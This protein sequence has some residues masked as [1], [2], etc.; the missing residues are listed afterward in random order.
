[1]V[2]GSETI[3][4]LLAGGYEV[5]ITISGQITRANIKW[6][7]Q[8]TKRSGKQPKEHSTAMESSP[9]DSTSCFLIPSSLLHPPPTSRGYGSTL[10][11]FRFWG[12]NLKGSRGGQIKTKRCD[13]GDGDGDDEDENKGVWRWG[14]VCENSGD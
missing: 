2:L 4:F 9:P 1:M 13:D 11:D 7:S 6:L 5:E 14:G 3:S 8:M 10:P 12:I